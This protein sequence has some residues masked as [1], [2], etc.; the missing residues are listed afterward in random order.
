[1]LIEK[2]FRLL[3][4]TV[5]SYAIV[6]SFDVNFD[7]RGTYEGFIRG[8]I[9]FVDGSV[10]HLREFIDVELTIDRLMYV[11]HYL[12]SS[13]MLVFRYDDTGH[14]KELNLSTFPHHK[15]DGSEDNI[16]SS[17]VPDLKTV[18]DEIEATIKLL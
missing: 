13:N 2:Y 6:Q 7:K 16:I 11:Y 5:D 4:K 17:P 1:L 12:D 14:H 18:L 9:Y 10:L 8:E 15:H 3:Q